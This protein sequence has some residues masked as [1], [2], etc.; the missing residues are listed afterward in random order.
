MIRQSKNFLSAKVVLKNRRVI[1]PKCCHARTIYLTKLT[2]RSKRKT[3]KIPRLAW[4]NLS[5]TDV[6]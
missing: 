5:L 6:R 3:K 2:V 4:K 1:C